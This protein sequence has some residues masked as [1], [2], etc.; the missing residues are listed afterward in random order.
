M[1]GGHRTG[2]AFLR[3]ADAFFDAVGEVGAARADVGAEDVGAVTLVVY[4][5]RQLLLRVGDRRG[6]TEDVRGAAATTD[7]RKAHVRWGGGWRSPRPSR[8]RTAAAAE[9]VRV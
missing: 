9:S 1:T 7:S 3:L 2:T 4:A 5:A 8:V 6:V